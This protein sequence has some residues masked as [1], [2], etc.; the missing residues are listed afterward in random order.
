MNLLPGE[1]RGIEKRGRGGSGYWFKLKIIYSFLYFFR[2]MVQPIFQFIPVYLI[3]GIL[4]I[5]LDFL[6]D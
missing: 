5:I 4:E 3:S 2:V 6:I 1:M